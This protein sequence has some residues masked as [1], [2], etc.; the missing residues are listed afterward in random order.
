[1]GTA[2]DALMAGP[3]S[4]EACRGC[5]RGAATTTMKALIRHPYIATPVTQKFSN[6]NVAT[7]G[8][9]NHSESFIADSESDTK[10]P[11]V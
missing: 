4:Q 8:G 5:L 9:Q 7:A 11:I 10:I 6:P 2:G 1:M 3:N